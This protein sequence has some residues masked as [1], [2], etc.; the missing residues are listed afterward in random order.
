[1]WNDQNLDQGSSS[2]SVSVAPLKLVKI[3]VMEYSMRYFSFI[4][5]LFSGLILMD[6]CKQV[7]PTIV[8]KSTTEKRSTSKN[9]SGKMVTF[10][11]DSTI[12]RKKSTYDQII[13]D[14]KGNF[15][16]VTVT[17]KKWDLC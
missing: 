11:I 12:D 6:F 7:K 16:E 3:S 8:I 13:F 10:V 4:Y 1:M 14:D 9:T 15:I 2:A 17:G 5:I